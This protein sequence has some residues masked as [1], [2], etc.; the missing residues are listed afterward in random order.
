M[1][2]LGSENGFHYDPRWEV[3]AGPGNE[4]QSLSFLGT[5]SKPVPTGGD[6]VV[7]I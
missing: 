2:A 5:S 3:V 6:Y 4:L 1:E 7:F